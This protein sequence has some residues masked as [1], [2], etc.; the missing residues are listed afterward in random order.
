M[1]FVC[2]KF[3]TSDHKQNSDC[4][5]IFIRRLQLKAFQRNNIESCSYSLH[6]GTDTAV[7]QH[8]K[9]AKEKHV[10]CDAKLSNFRATFLR[11][12]RSDLTLHLAILNYRYPWMINNTDRCHDAPKCVKKCR[13][14]TSISSSKHT[15][16]NIQY[17]VCNINNAKY[18]ASNRAVQRE[19][20]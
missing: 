17:A 19:M 1:Q 6:F 2:I 11:P 10:A 3:L 8:D 14:V 20:G 7:K 12:K 16:S 5:T 18:F 15:I 4:C 13:N 9:G